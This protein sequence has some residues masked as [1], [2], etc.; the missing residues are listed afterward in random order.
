MAALAAFPAEWL[1][2]SAPPDLE[3]FA[4]EA[5][6]ATWHRILDVLPYGIWL[7]VVR[8]Q[9]GSLLG[10]IVAHNVSNV[11]QEALGSLGV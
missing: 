1:E 9:S 5:T 3:T 11:I 7:A 8:L 10:G 6:A 2:P 4:F